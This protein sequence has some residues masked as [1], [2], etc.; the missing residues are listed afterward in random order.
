M[1]ALHQLPRLKSIILEVYC[2]LDNKLE[3]QRQQHDQLGF[4]LLGCFF[5]F[6]GVFFVFFFFLII[7]MY[8]E[9][10]TKYKNS[11]V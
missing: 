4:S 2:I 7:I 1:Q 8:Q 10:N 5:F 9:L 6:G 3:L 11:E